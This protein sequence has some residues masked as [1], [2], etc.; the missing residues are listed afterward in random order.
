VELRFLLNGKAVTARTAPE[1]M[2]LDVLRNDYGTQSLRRGCKGGECGICSVLLDGVP[3]LS[4]MIPMFKI[5]GSDVV[6][7]EGLR[8]KREYQALDLA[9]EE[10]GFHPCS[11]CRPSTMILACSILDRSLDPKES[12]IID[13]YSG[14][15]CSCTNMERLISVIR[16][17]GRKMK[18]GSRG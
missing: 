10:A 8:E 5:A 12:E 3:V 6:T 9:Y 4:C 15:S 17:A 13:A 11:Y 2:L 7:E 16:S 18:R 1:R 14:R